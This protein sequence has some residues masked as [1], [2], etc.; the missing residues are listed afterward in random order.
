MNLKLKLFPRFFGYFS[1]FIL[2]I[3]FTVL[4]I[5]VLYISN[6]VLFGTPIQ[7]LYSKNHSASLR[8]NFGII[9][10]SV[11]VNVD[12]KEVY[13]SGDIWGISERE[14]RLTLIW[15][16]TGRVVALERM[17]KIVL[18]YDANNQKEMKLNE[19]NGY[20]LS[21]MPEI[22]MLEN[23]VVCNEN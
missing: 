4:L 19:L 8:R 3:I 5:P 12:G 9:D 21:P 22:Y 17:G 16:K 2:G 7:T 1:C 10:Y 20:C 6:E 15:D 18:A 11:S 23:Q 14:L 13:S